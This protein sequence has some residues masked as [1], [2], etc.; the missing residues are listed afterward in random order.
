MNVR[1]ITYVY[2][3]PKDSLQLKNIEELPT[4]NKL[5]AL[6]PDFH[7]R[8]HITTFPCKL[9]QNLSLIDKTK[10]KSLLKLQHFGTA[11]D[12]KW[13][14]AQALIGRGWRHRIKARKCIQI[15]RIKYSHCR[16]FFELE[17]LSMPDWRTW[18]V[19]LRLFGCIYINLFAVLASFLHKAALQRS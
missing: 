10:Y 18:N 4:C 15:A 11:F 3:V 16:L 2:W 8:K 7:I 17:L 19:I 12:P 14:Q 13:L 1:S 5:Q 6:S 9:A